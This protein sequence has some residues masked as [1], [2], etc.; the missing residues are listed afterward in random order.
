MADSSI[1]A[2]GVQPPPGSSAPCWRNAFSIVSARKGRPNATDPQSSTA[3][4]QRYR[5]SPTTIIKYLRRCGIAIRPSRFLGTEIPEAALRRLYLEQRL[6][7]V[8]IAA[9]FGVSVS[10]IN[11]KR[12]RYNIPIRPRRVAPR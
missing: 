7:L 3:I 12:R 5:C 8:V 2:R 1:A 9:Y 10:T 6:P 4:A 11:N